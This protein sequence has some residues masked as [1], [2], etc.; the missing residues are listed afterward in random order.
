VVSDSVQE[1]PGFLKDT[2]QSTYNESTTKINGSTSKIND[3]MQTVFVKP[4]VIT[5]ESG[6][7]TEAIIPPPDRLLRNIA[8]VVSVLGISVVVP[9]LMRW[10]GV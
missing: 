8:T 4:P 1:K 2:P 6:T 9:I 5:S 3:S 7:Q 10:A